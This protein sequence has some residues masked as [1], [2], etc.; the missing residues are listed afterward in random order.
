MNVR[1]AVALRR[2]HYTTTSQQPAK[3]APVR[4]RALIIE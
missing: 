2:N 4:R 1:R 3:R